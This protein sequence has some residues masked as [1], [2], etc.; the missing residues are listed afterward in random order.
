MTHMLNSIDE[1]IDRKFLV[2]KP[3]KAQ[4][5]P[6]HVIHVLNATKRKDGYLVEYRVTD[7]GK[8]YSFRDYAAV[9]KTVAD[10][11]KWARPDTFIA[12]HYEAFDLKEIQNYIKV[13]D[14]SF[15]SFALPII[16]VG[17]VVVWALGLFVVTGG[18]GIALAIIGSL[19]VAGGVSYFFRWQK[20]K[21]KL[22]LY[23]K[24]STNWGVS[25]K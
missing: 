10:F 25:F 14:R 19:V 16:L 23:G 6:G 11:C 24:I 8:G 9:F 7:V 15:V 21:V 5:E 3:M 22:D 17:L 4:A 2:T 1:A 12:R 13:S 18:K 20:S